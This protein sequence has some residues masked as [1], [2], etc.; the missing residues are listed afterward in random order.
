MSLPGG[1]ELIAAAR[2]VL[3]DALEALADQR[4]A[5]VLVGAQ[6]VFLHT[7]AA[8]VALPE[9]TKDTDLAIDRR[10]LLRSPLLEDAMSRAGFTHGMNPGSWVGALGVPVDLM[11]PECMSDPGGRRGGRIPPHASDATRKA[12]GLEAAIIDNT[13][14]EVAALDPSDARSYAIRVAGPAALVVTKLHKLRDRR[15]DNPARLDDK[16]AHDVYR[17]LVAV[18]T[19]DLLRGLQTLLASELASGATR[20]ALS[21]FDALFVAGPDALGCRM[22]GRAESLVG[23]PTTVAQSTSAL[24]EDLAKAVEGYRSLPAR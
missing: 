10:R 9:F 12:S 1:N 16:D 21:H 11:V 20:A 14:M 7:G 24:A 18:P 13:V 15:E 8:P 6:A 22:A 23:D 3:L 19:P 5:V 2:G 17:L 4:E